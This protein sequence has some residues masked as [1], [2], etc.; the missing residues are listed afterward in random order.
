MMRTTTMKIM[1]KAMA[2]MV[3]VMLGVEW[4]HVQTRRRNLKMKRG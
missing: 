2:L 4:I 3:I 1:R